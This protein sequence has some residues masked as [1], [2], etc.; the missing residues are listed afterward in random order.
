M[1]PHSFL[2]VQEYSWGTSGQR[3]TAKIYFVRENLFGCS[4]EDVHKIPKFHQSTDELNCSAM[5][6]NDSRQIHQS[7]VLTSVLFLFLNYRTGKYTNE[8]IYHSQQNKNYNKHMKQFI[9]LALH[10]ALDAFLIT[11]R[12]Q[13]K[14]TKSQQRHWIGPSKQHAETM[15][16]IC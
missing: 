8:T 6:W 9:V 14:N 12:Q 11:L 5:N 3:V 7:T 16:H 15:C 2:Y 4:L 13:F 10:I 1:K